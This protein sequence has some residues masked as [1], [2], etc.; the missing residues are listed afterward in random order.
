MFGKSTLVWAIFVLL[1]QSWIQSQV[2]A[3]DKRQIILNDQKQTYPIGTQAFIF[4]TT[5]ANIT[6]DQI[7]S[8]KYDQKFSLSKVQSIIKGHSDSFFWIMV[9]VQN[10]SKS[11]DWLLEY[12][13]P[14]LD[15]VDFYYFDSKSQKW[16]VIE[17]GDKRLFKNRPIFNRQFVFPINFKAS[18]HQ[19]LYLRVWGTGTIQIPLEIHSRA[20]FYKKASW[21]DVIYGLLYGVL[22]LILA[23]S[24][25]L[26]ISLKDNSY[27]FYIIFV[28]GS[29]LFYPADSGHSY[30]YVWPT[31]IYWA[32]RVI[33]FGL[34]VMVT[35]SAIFAIF[36]LNIQKYS[37]GLFRALQVITVVSSVQVVLSFILPFRMAIEIISYT[38]LLNSIILIASGVVSWRKG[39]LASRYFTVAWIIYT[40]GIILHALK[41]F[42]LLPERAV[43]WHSTEVSAVIEV[44]LLSMALGDK[45]NIFKAEKEKLS[46]EMLKMQEQE[47]EELER[48]V[49]E[50]T[51][52]L[53][54]TNEELNQTIEELDLTNEQLNKMNIELEKKNSDITESINYAKRI[55]SAMLPHDTYVTQDFPQHF[56]FFRPRDIVSGD[57]YWFGKKTVDSIDYQVLIV[58]DCTGHG[59]PGAFMTILASSII[60][61][62]I[63]YQETFKPEAILYL[64]DRKLN[65]TLQSQTGSKVNDGM[66]MSIVVINEETQMLYFAGAKSP[67][68]YVRDE[69]F[70]Q[71]KGS[72]F[73]IGGSDQYKTAKQF[74]GHELKLQAGDMLYLS[75]DGFQDQFSKEMGGKYLKKN[76]RNLLLRIS[77]LP[78]EEQA[79]QLQMELDNWKGGI[80][81]T[82]DILIVGLLI[83]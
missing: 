28:L 18:S 55:Q 4:E 16:D 39:N 80:R 68:Y 23:H 56:I 72:I 65:E 54:E 11:L 71:I 25:F 21:S 29:L 20:H 37:K 63:K 26:Y 44:V 5:D 2:F 57:F 43:V 78:I 75:S 36:F 24:F 66:D 42:G 82:D 59:V 22:V 53:V 8:G 61:E 14:T 9:D 7:A 41:D 31:Q 67:L 35:G 77:S 12:A 1:C 60:H 15:Y 19:R 30:Q 46:A 27:L 70:H 73:P 64:L 10:N 79:Q 40:F 33:P 34:A 83:E 69:V 51:A 49:S 6:I 13:Y 52:K 48:K 58:A 50:R 76:Y 38:I 47:N 32:N 3:Q 62:I 74:D 45:Y 17:T 81:Q